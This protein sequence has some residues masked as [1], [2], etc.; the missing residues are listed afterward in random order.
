MALKSID[1][2]KF[3][4]EEVTVKLAVQHY[5][6]APVQKTT[7]PHPDARIQGINTPA[8][9][10]IASSQEQGPSSTSQI[11]QLVK[12]KSKEIYG[13]FKK[14]AKKTGAKGTRRGFFF[15]AYFL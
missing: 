10:F 2:Y 14:T 9:H 13:M 11:L 8:A 6:S 3:D 1:D 4:D 12:P 15:F 5:G 7:A